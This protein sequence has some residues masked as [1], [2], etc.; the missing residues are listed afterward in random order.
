VEYLLTSLKI[1]GIPSRCNGIQNKQRMIDRS[2]DHPGLSIA[3]NRE[4]ES[5]RKKNLLCAVSVVDA[6]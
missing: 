5:A 1:A 4:R 6:D 2:I 3:K